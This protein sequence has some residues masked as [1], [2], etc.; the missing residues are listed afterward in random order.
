MNKLGHHIMLRLRDDRV[1]APSPNALCSVARIVLRIGQS[2]RLLTF[3]TAD[4]HIHIESICERKRAGQFARRVELAVGRK[5]RLGSSFSPAHVKPI[6]DQRHLSNGFD[7]ICSQQQRHGIANDPYR[8]GSNLPDLLGMR[9]IGAYTAD[10]VRAF[11]PRINRQQLLSYFDDIDLEQ[12]CTSLRQLYEASAAAI[13]RVELTGNQPDVVAARR[14]AVHLAS[15]QLSTV[16][17]AELLRIRPRAA[18]RLRLKPPAPPLLKAIDLQLRLRS[19]AKAPTAIP[20][21]AA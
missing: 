6:E 7:Y 13:G 4:S 12:P 1:I 9:V 15:A 2:F 19:G 17:I 16:E 8:D 5:L 11:L 10:N 14:A 3:C 18:R 21:V 20:F